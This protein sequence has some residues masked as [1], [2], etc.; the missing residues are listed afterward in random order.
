[1][2]AKGA[3]KICV[4]AGPVVEKKTTQKIT[5]WPLKLPRRCDMGCSLPISSAKA[6]LLAMLTFKGAE[7]CSPTKSPERRER[8]LPTVAQRVTNPTSIHEDVGSVP[9][10]AQWVE[11]LALL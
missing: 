1:M 2:Q 9:G 6:S 11:D 5:H 8:G 4:L 7:R 10:L 3:A